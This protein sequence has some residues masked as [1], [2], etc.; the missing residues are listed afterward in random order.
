MRALSWPDAFPATDLG[1]RK[2]LNETNLT[3]VLQIA[4]AWQPWRSYATMHLWKS[5]EKPS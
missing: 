2:A 3:R 1:V 4:K 5:L